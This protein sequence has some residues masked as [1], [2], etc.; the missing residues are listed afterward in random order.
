MTVS[1]A[2][3]DRL[4]SGLQRLLAGTPIRSHTTDL[5]VAN[6]AR[7]SGVSRAT[8]NRAPTILA[9]LRAAANH[10]GRNPDTR[11]RTELETK[12]ADL[13]KEIKTLRRRTDLYAQHIMAL[14]AD[15]KRLLASVTEPGAVVLLRQPSSPST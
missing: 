14:T 7:E 8:A 4:R 10:N 13:Q 2:A 5:T 1:K 11:R 15:N 12:M 9:D 3:E 6:L